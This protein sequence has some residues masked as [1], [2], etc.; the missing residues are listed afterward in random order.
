VNTLPTLGSLYQYLI[1]ELSKADIEKPQLEARILIAFAAGFDQTQIF[2]YPEKVIKPELVTKI[3]G[4]IDRRKA[5]EPIAYI[6]G[7]QEFWSLEFIVTKDTLIPR[8]DSE[9]LVEAVLATI[10]D[11][12][13][14]L[15]ILDL[16]TGSG[17]LLL[18]LLSELPHTLGVGVDIS[19]TACKIAK[20]NGKNLGLHNRAKFYQ[21]DWLNGIE[22]TFDIIVT[23][24]PYIADSQIL[25]LERDV[26]DFE[27]HIALSGG[28]DGLVAY[29]K[30]LKQC[31]KHLNIGGLLAVE[32]GVNQLSDIQ[33][34]LANNK[35]KL[36]SI[37][38]DFGN[39]DRCILATHKKSS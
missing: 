11:K 15:N 32:I 25:L 4:L 9:I 8:P 30:I 24:P 29:K 38:S 17:C 21:G 12:M 31:T 1:D 19:P 23:N 6:T 28:L 13:A 14:P 35:F 33:I 2:G 16:G 3:S 26:K 7:N 34:I 36:I 10:V 37:H 27:P 20:Q 22:N 39:I 5:S 18:A